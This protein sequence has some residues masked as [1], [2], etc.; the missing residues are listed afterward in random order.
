MR[1]I[2][3]I[4]IALIS[5]FVLSGCDLESDETKI[6][7]ILDTI[8][9]CLDNKDSASFKVL[10]SD[11]AITQDTDIDNEIESLFSYYEGT[12]VS[13]FKWG[14]AISTHSEYG[15]GYKNYSCSC[16]ITTTTLVY[17]MAVSIYTKNDFDKTK[18]G[19]ESFYLLK[20]KDDPNKDYAYHGDGL[21]TV[22]CNIG[23][24][25]VEENED[26]SL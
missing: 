10:F 2:K 23:K 20:E 12:Q 14:N 3:T 13:I 4:I 6:N 21:W 24:V 15:K 11:Y 7:R 26:E 5:L 22:G 17:R 19:I 8:V 1:K 18:I 9:E 16:D 25:M